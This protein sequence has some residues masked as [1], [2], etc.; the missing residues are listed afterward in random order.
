[1]DDL[2]M[3]ILEFVDYY[4]SQGYPEEQALDYWDAL[5]LDY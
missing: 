2:D 4:M 1:M 3:N 5:H